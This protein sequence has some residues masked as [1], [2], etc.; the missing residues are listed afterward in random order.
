MKIRKKSP[1]SA[2][3]NYKREIC[4]IILSYNVTNS[5]KQQRQ[6]NFDQNMHQISEKIWKFKSLLAAKLGD[7]NVSSSTNHCGSCRKKAARL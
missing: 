5:I 1:R 2:I 6:R 4:Y 7:F 3:G